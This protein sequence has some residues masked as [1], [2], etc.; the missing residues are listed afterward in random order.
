[1]CIEVSIARGVLGVGSGA[2]LRLGCFSSSSLRCVGSGL[3]SVVTEVPGGI[4]GVCRADVC[5]VLCVEVLGFSIGC[6]FFRGLL[7]WALR[8]T[9]SGSGAWLRLTRGLVWMLEVVSVWL[10]GNFRL[11]LCC[12]PTGG[13]ASLRLA[14]QMGSGFGR[15]AK[16][17]HFWGLLDLPL[18]P[19]LYSN[20][21]FY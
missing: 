16:F 1:M 6:F 14:P 7:V 8:W 4:R 9:G 3:R 5:S 21:I 18:P 17:W 12:L 15:I 11:S 10:W 20:P 13:G 19:H 2:L